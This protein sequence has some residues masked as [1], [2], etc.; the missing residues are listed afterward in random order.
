MSNQD[1]SMEQRL[2]ALA[3]GELNQTESEELLC[4][5]E[6]D[7]DLRGE[8]CDIHRIK[9]MMHYAYSENE[10]TLPSKDSSGRNGIAWASAAT[11]L[12]TLGVLTGAMIPNESQLNKTFSLAQI[13]T[14][15]PNK[16]VLYLN[17]SD[18]TKFHA[19]LEKAEFL[20]KSDQTHGVEVDVVVSA[21]G[22]DMLR[23]VNSPIYGQIKTLSTNYDFV[24]FV[25]CSKTLERQK[26]EGKPVK[27][28]REAKVAPS[29][30]EFIVGRLQ[31]GWSYMAI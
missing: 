23:D 18:E 31:E 24:Q 7:P 10:R 15:Q 14:Y 4:L 8:L 1:M 27:L 25:A 29:A 6:Q 12:F 17:D 13:E 2:N 20:L 11:I 30:V 21:G 16:F 19:A 26:L 9:D 22:I 3:D 28:V 5:I